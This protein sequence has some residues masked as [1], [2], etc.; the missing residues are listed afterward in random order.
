MSSNDFEI[1]LMLE[2]D[3]SSVIPIE[4]VCYPEPWSKETF[5]QGFNC[6]EYEAIVCELNKKIIG[7]AIFWFGVEEVHIL[8]ITVEPKVQKRGYGSKLLNYVLDYCSKEKYPR[9][10]L[11]V[12]T[13]NI[14]AI[15]L[16]KSKGF[17]QIGV[18]LGYYSNGDD[19][20][21]MEL[22]R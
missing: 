7:Y 19:A 5:L 20:L 14:P 8:N 2:E 21:V 1:R 4:N 17:A 3:I 16:Y 6:D 13:K 15:A 11:E 9:V 22:C 12:R 10:L 18:R